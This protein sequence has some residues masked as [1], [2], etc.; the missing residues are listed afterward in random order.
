LFNI[1]PSPTDESGRNQVQDGDMFYARYSGNFQGS[2]KRE[3]PLR[4]L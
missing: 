3:R 4:E 1:T 2:S